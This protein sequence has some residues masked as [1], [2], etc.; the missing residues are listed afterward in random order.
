MLFYKVFNKEGIKGV[1]EC[2]NFDDFLEVREKYVDET[3]E[4]QQIDQTEF[5]ELAKELD[6][7]NVSVNYTFSGG[8]EENI[9]YSNTELKIMIL[10]WFKSYSATVPSVEELDKYY[11]WFK[12]ED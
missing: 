7:N 11:Q 5:N 6:E 3:D 2:E 10:N 4:I 9:K 1:F 8:M 12:S